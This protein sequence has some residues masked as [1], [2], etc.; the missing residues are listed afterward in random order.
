MNNVVILDDEPIARRI[1]RNYLGRLDGYRIVAECGNVAE[2]EDFLQQHPVDLLFL[3]IEMPQTSGLQYLRQQV[4][5]PKV[6]IVSAH[7]HYAVEG[8]E[9]DVLDYL[10]KP[11]SFERFQ[12]A[13]DKFSRQKEQEQTEEAIMLRVDRMNLRIAA[14]EI[15]YVES[16]GDYL[17]VHCLDKMLITKETLKALAERLPEQFLQV[18]R[19]CIINMQHLQAYSNEQLIV[20]GNKVAVSRSYKKAVA[21]A[22]RK[23]GFV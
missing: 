15:K 10:L 4:L 22:I 2:C 12:Q 7:R 5:Q 1:L 13:L 3:D 8:F 6:I 9:F 19:S 14:D 17:K 16:M 18:H 23:T 20:A 11:V 21:E